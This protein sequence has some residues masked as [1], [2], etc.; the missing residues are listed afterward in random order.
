MKFKFEQNHKILFFC[1]FL[2]P[3]IGL[4]L[5][6]YTPSL[7]AITEHFHISH[8]A[9]KLTI[10]LYLAGFGI[11][12]PFVGIICDR[13]ERKLFITGSLIL[14]FLSALGS[15]WSLSIDMFYVFRII[16]SI[17][18]S[19]IGVSIKSILLDHFS[20][21]GLAKANNYFTMGWSLTPMIAPVI[22]GYLQHY[23]GWQYNFYF[24]GFYSFIAWLLAIYFLPKKQIQKEVLFISIA[25]KWKILFS[26]YRFV[27]SIF[28]LSVENIILFI[29][30]TVAPF[31]I[32]NTLH[33][34]A[35]QYGQIILLVGVFYL[36]GN[37]L[38]GW[39]LNHIQLEKIIGAGIAISIL[40]ALM[41]M[42]SLK[43]M[44]VSHHAL[45]YFVTIPIYF[46]FLC[47]GFIFANVMTMALSNYS[48]F[49]GTAAGLLV[50]LLNVV[51]A[52]AVAACARWLDLH[53]L[54]ILNTTYFVFLC[55]SLVLF[56]LT[57]KNK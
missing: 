55:I 15:A 42:A 48:R 16:N 17:S 26:D 13:I 40:F 11:A 37:I 57:K 8:Y 30:Y 28:I 50:G 32:Q 43:L 27:A 23:F 33:F 14:Y 19:C 2:T 3:L 49:S 39:L 9:A 6:L 45:I 21:K 38:N 41:S 1:L 56:F 54:F 35:A 34:N 31:I 47:D 18:G 36:L 53:N 25:K 46:I 24:M 10:I 20:G 5:D 51:A 44:T 22:G 52:I 29:Y 4:G 12:Q 7:P